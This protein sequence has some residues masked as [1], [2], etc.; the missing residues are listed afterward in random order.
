MAC[1][2]REPYVRENLPTGVVTAWRVLCSASTLL[3]DVAQALIGH[4]SVDH[5]VADRAMAHEGLQR[6]GIDATAG[7]NITG[8]VP[9]HVSVQARQAGKRAEA[10]D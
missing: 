5:C 9:E 2:W 4:R 8:A 3:P 7:E 10:L 6:P 1:S